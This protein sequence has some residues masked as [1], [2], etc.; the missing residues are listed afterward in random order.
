MLRFKLKV[1]IRGKSDT[2]RIADERVPNKEELNRILRIATPNGRVSIALM[3]LS[4]D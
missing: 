4:M 3:W 1:N 2:P